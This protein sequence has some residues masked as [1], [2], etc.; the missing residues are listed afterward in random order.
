M[1]AIS[2]WGRPFGLHGEPTLL[3]VLWSVSWLCRKGCELKSSGK[4]PGLG[5]RHIGFF[6]IDEP[7]QDP[8]DDGNQEECAICVNGTL[9]FL[10]C[11]QPCGEDL[12]DL[13]YTFVVF[14]SRSG[15]QRKA[16]GLTWQRIGVSGKAGPWEAFQK[17]WFQPP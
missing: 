4:V 15:E 10:A 5:A 3:E 12:V 2:A 11:I 6:E 9:K 1:L 17:P 13:S 16:G 7:R 8:Q 14:S